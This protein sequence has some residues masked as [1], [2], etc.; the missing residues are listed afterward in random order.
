LSGKVLE[1]DY[2][3]DD[4]S[5]VTSCRPRTPPRRHYAEELDL[6]RQMVRL[7]EMYAY[8][9][10]HDSNRIGVCEARDF[11]IESGHKE[12]DDDDILQIVQA[13]CPA[14][15]GGLDFTEIWDWFVGSN[16][17]E[18]LDLSP[19]MK[20]MPERHGEHHRD[21]EGRRHET[22]LKHF[23]LADMDYDGDGNVTAE[24]MQKW[25]RLRAADADKDGN[26]TQAEIDAHHS[27][28]HNDMV[29]SSSMKDEN[30]NVDATP[31]ASAVGAGHMVARSLRKDTDPDYKARIPTI[32]I[33]KLQNRPAQVAPTKPRP[34]ARPMTA[35]PNIASRGGSSGG[36]RPQT[37]RLNTQRQ[38]GFQATVPATARRPQTARP[39]NDTS[40]SNTFR[41]YTGR[42]NASTPRNHVKVPE[43][44]K[45]AWVV[46]PKTA[47]VGCSSGFR[48]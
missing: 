29:K 9:V 25:R 13:V 5:N 4:G 26:V 14:T 11:L 17:V 1:A 39:G 37:A 48:V 46:G 34:P 23:S 12:P 40:G 30:A 18:V 38:G 36:S 7:K 31:T 20:V 42:S 6:Y 43:L 47:K 44:F 2:I 15:N 8:C 16:L 35:R 27:K 10:A 21:G 33:S 24:E 28:L 22:L 45:Q 41:C 32:Q 19:Q 3:H